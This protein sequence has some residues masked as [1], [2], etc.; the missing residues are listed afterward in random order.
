MSEQVI[1]LQNV[2]VEFNTPKF[3]YSTFKEFVLN[4]LKGRTGG[5]TFRALNGITL[6]IE[7]GKSVALI[8]HNGSG[9][10]T[11]LRVMAGIY[12]PPNAQ[13]TV[14][15]RI[16]P[17]IEL[18]AGFDGELTGRENIMLSC[19]LMG[20][21]MS[22]IKHRI[23]D[24][25]EFSE[26]KD[27]IDMPFKNYSS[28][29]QA[30]L[31]FACVSAVD[32]D[33]LLIDEV[34]AVGDSNF[35]KKCL[36][37]IRELQA[38][39][40]TLVLVSHDAGT[41]SA[42]CEYGYVL[43]R[44]NLVFEGP[45]QE[46]LDAH[47][48]IMAKRANLALSQSGLEELRRQRMLAAD[49]NLR[50]AGLASSVTPRAEVIFSVDQTGFKERSLLKLQEPFSLCFSVRLED[51][52]HFENDVSVGFGLLNESG[53]RVG[54]LNNLQKQIKIAINDLRSSQEIQVQFEFKS[55]L[56]DLAGGIYRI[57]FGVH[58]QNISRSIVLSEF[59]PLMFQ[60]ENDGPGSRGDILRLAEKDISLRIDLL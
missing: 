11:L 12:S 32:P 56:P 20:L 60:N 46:A 31:G 8:G 41:L 4:V 55:G 10:S 49:E 17:M 43:E 26:L 18:G 21:E 58:D 15:G 29:M 7:K 34:L 19:A 13:M 2:H 37:R 27:F 25:I 54:G 38:K 45:I 30:R 14:K 35:A 52:Q 28:G 44:G 16:A 5:D 53:T 47:E 48:R 57:L 36:A 33:I 23:D 50:N 51:S 6:T 59:G 40:A 22:E 42:F 24:I 1:A 9:K 39:G 3:A